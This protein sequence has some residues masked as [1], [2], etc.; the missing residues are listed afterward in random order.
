MYMVNGIHELAK[1][2]VQDFHQEADA[3]RTM[4]S[5]GKSSR[6]HNRTGL[7]VTL[8]ALFPGF[9]RRDA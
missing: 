8:A 7:M 1:G 4:E 2:K 5:A 6:A 3:R 9:A